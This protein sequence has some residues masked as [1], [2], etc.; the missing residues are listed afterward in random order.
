MISEPSAVQAMAS[1]TSP[2][3]VRLRESAPVGDIT[4]SSERAPV[5]RAYASSV[6]SGE[7]R[8]LP[9]RTS[10]GKLI[11]RTWPLPPPP[12]LPPLPPVPPPPPPQLA[13]ETS[14]TAR[15]AVWL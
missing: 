11:V 5:S 15:I 1:R 14:T 9:P 10:A 4:A 12:P 6:P 7:K 8:G 2:S 3:L 13:R